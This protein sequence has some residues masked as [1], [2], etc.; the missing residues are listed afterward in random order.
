VIKVGIG[1]L[2]VEKIGIIDVGRW[3]YPKG[4]YERWVD[5]T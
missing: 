5:W 3:D 2:L 1:L 4:R